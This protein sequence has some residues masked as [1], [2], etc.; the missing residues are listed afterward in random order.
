MKS[1]SSPNPHVKALT[2]YVPIFGKSAF[3]VIK[4]K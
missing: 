4:V 3:K 1:V 2:P